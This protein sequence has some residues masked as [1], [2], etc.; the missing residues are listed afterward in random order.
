MCHKLV[1]Q[2]MSK[3]GLT[4]ALDSIVATGL[5]VKPDVGSKKDQSLRNHKNNHKGTNNDQK[6]PA[7]F[8]PSFE[9]KCCDRG[10]D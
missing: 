9:F 8:E 6:Y 3:I 10:R 2:K 7:R 5:N 4:E 1:L